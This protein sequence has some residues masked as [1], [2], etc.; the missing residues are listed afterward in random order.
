MEGL[1]E[2]LSSGAPV[3]HQSKSFLKEMFAAKSVPVYTNTFLAGINDDGVIVKPSNSEEERVLEADDV[4]IAVGFRP[5]PSFA[6]EIEGCGAE[7]YEV[8]DGRQ[9]ANILNAVWDAYEVARNI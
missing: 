5:L 9:V 1:P 8:G 7:I 3:P 4:V 2:I 6:R